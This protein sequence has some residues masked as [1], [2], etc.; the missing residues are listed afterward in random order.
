MNTAVLL[1]RI[2]GAPPRLKTRVSFACDTFTHGSDRSTGL[3]V[4]FRQPIDL[5][6]GANRCA[7]CVQFAVGE[8]F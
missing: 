6:G 3:G 4:G 7:L 1:E 2:A 8:I 5:K